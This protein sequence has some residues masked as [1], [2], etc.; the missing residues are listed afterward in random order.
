VKA[1]SSVDPDHHTLGRERHARDRDS[2]DGDE[3]I[4]CC[5]DLWTNRFFPGPKLF[6]GIRAIATDADWSA[7]AGLDV[8]GPIEAWV[9]TL[10]GRFDAVDLLQGNGAATL[11]MRVDAL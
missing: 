11:R 10:T 6:Q 2:V 8:T 5:G 1:L 9:L 3:A 7:G 4:K